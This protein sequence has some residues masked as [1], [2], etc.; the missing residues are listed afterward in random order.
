MDTV[1]LTIRAA[2]G[3]ADSKL[4]VEDM[5]SIYM[6]TCTLQGF[7]ATAVG[8]REGFV[9]FKITGKN[10]LKFFQ[11]EQ[12]SHR[13][14]RVPPTERNGRVQTS[15]IT[16]SVINQQQLPDLVINEADVE[17]WYTRGTG[18]GGQKINKT[19]C[20]ACLKHIP[21]GIIVKCQ[22]GRSQRHNEEKAWE[23]IKKKLQN[24]IQNYPK[25]FL[26]GYEVGFAALS[27]GIWFF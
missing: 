10:V 16:V 21:T 6:K 24:I 22:D 13:W 26:N 9:S 15:T 27:H 1:T 14:Q 11:Q 18:A 5:A 19:T 12:G 4:L 20:V 2:E 23:I 8:W 17:R 3:G 7:V 25:E